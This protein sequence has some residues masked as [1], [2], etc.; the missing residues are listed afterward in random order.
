MVVCRGSQVKYSI[1]L[2][3]VAVLESKEVSS[4]NK[5]IEIKISDWLGLKLRNDAEEDEFSFGV[6][7]YSIISCRTL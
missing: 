3:H 6:V 5:S 1:S 7:E 4:K 2:D